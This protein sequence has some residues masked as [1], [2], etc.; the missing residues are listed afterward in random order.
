[1]RN[2]GVENYEKP[3]GK[4]VSRPVAFGR[5]QNVVPAKGYVKTFGWGS[6]GGLSAVGTHQ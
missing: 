5:Q 3:R 4:L 2:Q 1:M 6:V